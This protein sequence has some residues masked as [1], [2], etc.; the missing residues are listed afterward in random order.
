MRIEVSQKTRLGSRQ[1]CEAAGYRLESYKS[2]YVPRFWFAS[3]SVHPHKDWHDRDRSAS[4]SFHLPRAEAYASAVA[5]C[6]RNPVSGLLPRGEE[7]SS[8]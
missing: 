4:A 2:P 3:V 5:F 6:E 8:D 7:Q 1:R